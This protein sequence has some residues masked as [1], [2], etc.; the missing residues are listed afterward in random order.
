[1]EASVEPESDSAENKG[2]ALRETRKTETERAPQGITRER[3]ED[4]RIADPANR[5]DVLIVVQSAKCLLFQRLV[6]L[7]SEQ[8]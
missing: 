6:D 2:P 3:H 1:M 8:E 5:S 7:Q 4:R